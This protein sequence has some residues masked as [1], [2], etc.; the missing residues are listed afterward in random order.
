MT[1]TRLRRGRR[2]SW[3]RIMLVMCH[4][5]LPPIAARLSTQEAVDL[6][7]RLWILTRMVAPLRGS[8]L[9]TNLRC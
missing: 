2:L 6:C 1:L 5:I 8:E 7:G 9:T 4:D 3:I